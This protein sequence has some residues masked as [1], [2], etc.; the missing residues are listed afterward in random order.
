MSR[1]HAIVLAMV[2]LVVAALGQLGS[3]LALWYLVGRIRALSRGL[4]GNP[5]RVWPT[6]SEF[7]DYVRKQCQKP[8]TE[9]LRELMHTADLLLAIRGV[10]FLAVTL[11]M[12]AVEFL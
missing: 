11:G 2:L 4:G 3:Q 1:L 12:L 6:E 10:T 9:E 8:G 7:W 5:P